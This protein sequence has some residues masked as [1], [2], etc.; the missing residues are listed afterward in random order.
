MKKLVFHLLLL[1]NSITYSNESPHELTVEEQ[2]DDLL[3]AVAKIPVK[4][5]ERPGFERALDILYLYVCTDVICRLIFQACNDGKTEIYRPVGPILA[6]V[7][8]LSILLNIRQ[9]KYPDFYTHYLRYLTNQINRKSLA[10]ALKYNNNLISASS[11]PQNFSTRYNYAIAQA[12][13]TKIIN[14]FEKLPENHSHNKQIKALLPQL[15][16]VS[17]AVTNIF[18]TLTVQ[19]LPT[20]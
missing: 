4:W 9:K 7:A 8:G 5:S 11:L 12:Y 14:L 15:K 1:C 13:L 18:S 16:T 6:T 19:N 17:Q 2:V 3:H 10:T 20:V